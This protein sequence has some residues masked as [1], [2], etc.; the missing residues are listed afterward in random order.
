MASTLA[1]F[2]T[3]RSGPVDEHARH[4]AETVLSRRLGTLSAVPVYTVRTWLPDRPGALGAVASRIGAVGGDV[5]GIDIIERGAG[6]AID[7]LVVDL[8]DGHLVDLL[9]AEIGEVEGVDVEHIR[10]LSGP[11]PDPTVEALLCA[12]S[13]HE[14]GTGIERFDRLVQ[15]ARRLLHADWAALVDATGS[16][17]VA[18]DGDDRPADGWLCAF[19]LGATAE[20]DPVALSDLALATLPESGIALVVSRH[21]APLRGRE[22]A[23]L[24]ALVALA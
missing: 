15:G 6:R 17:I 11:P 18:A 2:L 16:R 3:D 19:A 10:A 24:D 1:T 5:I 13:L 14:S 8:P 12:L 7:E 20:G 21:H 22:Q 4:L 9:L 23:V